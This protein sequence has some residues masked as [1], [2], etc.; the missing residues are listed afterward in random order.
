MEFGKQAIVIAF[1]SAQSVALRRERHARNDGKVNRF[2]IGEERACR[3]LN[4]EMSRSGKGGFIEVFMQL[5]F[6]ADNGGQEYLFPDGMEIFYQLMGLYFIGH[7]MVKEDGTYAIL[8]LYAVK[9]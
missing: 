2:I 5:K 3:F 4:T 8:L 1:S 7:G 9:Q 6:V